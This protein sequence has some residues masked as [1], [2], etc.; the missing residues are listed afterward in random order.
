M[1]LCTLPYERGLTDHR[2]DVHSPEGSRRY[3]NRW[4]SN[5]SVRLRFS[6]VGNRPSPRLPNRFMGPHANLVCH[7]FCDYA[8]FLPIVYQTDA[9]ITL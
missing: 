3:L 8:H 4:H 7:S 1:Q 5:D 6:T 9:M 2:H